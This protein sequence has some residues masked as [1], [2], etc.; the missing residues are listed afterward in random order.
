[1]NLS[2]ATFRGEKKPKP[3]MHFS[4]NQVFELIIMT[5]KTDSFGIFSDPIKRIIGSDKI[6]HI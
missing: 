4:G 6:K 3:L 5:A 2:N 1:M